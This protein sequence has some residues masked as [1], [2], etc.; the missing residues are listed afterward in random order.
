[1]SNEFLVVA[2]PPSKSRDKKLLLKNMQMFIYEIFYLC[3]SKNDYIRKKFYINQ[4]TYKN[5]IV[6]NILIDQRN[7][8]IYQNSVAC[9]LQGLRIHS[10]YFVVVP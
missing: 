6:N 9:N 10:K 5:L 2:L 7:S 4:C 1:M 8:N 3:R